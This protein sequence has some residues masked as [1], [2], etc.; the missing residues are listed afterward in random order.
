ME[1]RIVRNFTITPNELINDENI[2]PKARFLFVYLCSKP[3][4]WK[5]RPKQLQKALKMSKNTRLKY[6]KELVDAGWITT[7][8]QVGSDGEFGGMDITL[9][10]SPQL[11]NKATEPQ[12]KNAAAQNLRSAKIEPLNKT[13]L[14]TN[15]DLFNKKEEILSLPEIALN[16][17]NEKK[18][19]KIPFKPSND[20]LKHL[21]GLFKEKFTIE[22]IK[23]VIDFKIQDWKDSKKMK[24]Y[25]RPE[26]LFGDKFN[27]YLVEAAEYQENS[28]SSQPEFQYRPSKTVNL[29]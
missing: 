27:S 8:Q 23:A 4:D 7:K 19:S 13:D 1:N 16:Y 22:D 18:P 14:N 28:V 12:T 3:S 24:R 6:T 21:K 20:N 5:W 10:E 15:N 17:L 25:I 2:D 26:T 29:K 11:K 9:H